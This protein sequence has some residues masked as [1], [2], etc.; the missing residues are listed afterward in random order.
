M[1]DKLRNPRFATAAMAVMIALAVVLGGGRSLRA[2]KR[3]VD[4]IFWN[5]VDG[6]GI[7]VASDL[8]KNRDDAY[9]LLSVARGYAVP[10]ASLDALEG[11]ISDFDE[12]GRDAGKLA[13]ANTALTRA[14]TALYEDLGRQTLSARDEGYR[15]SLYHNVLARSDTMRRDGYNAAAQAF[16]QKLGRFPASVLRVI[17]FVTPAPLFR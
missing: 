10:Q 4:D 11:A 17:T 16:N 5:G 13:E 3:G 8:C 6:D 1:A 15:Q 2:L 14:L 9:N 12:S 7:G